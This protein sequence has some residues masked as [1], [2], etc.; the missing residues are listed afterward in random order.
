MFELRQI[1]NFPFS[2]F[3]SPPQL[4]YIKYI[5]KQQKFSNTYCAKDYKLI[6]PFL[7]PIKSN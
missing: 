3:F 7:D 1:L 2:L 6:E 5:K 4:F